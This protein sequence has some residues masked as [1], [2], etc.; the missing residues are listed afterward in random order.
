MVD[1]WNF[2]TETSFEIFTKEMLEEAWDDQNECIMRE[3]HSDDIKALPDDAIW[4]NNSRLLFEDV[5]AILS[6]YVDATYPNEIEISF[7][8][9]GAYYPACHYMPNGDPGYPEEMDEER[10]ITSITICDKTFAE[11][12]PEFRLLEREFQEDVDEVEV[13]YI[14]QI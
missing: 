1:K 8:C 9:K 5:C 11:G 12:D 4:F 3:W 2:D 7:R 13:N 14:D 10:I 6:K